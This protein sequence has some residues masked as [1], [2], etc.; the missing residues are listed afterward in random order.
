MVW[1]ASDL[2]GAKQVLP[3]CHE[4]SIWF[5]SAPRAQSSRALDEP[6]N[7]SISSLQRATIPNSPPPPPARVSG[8][9]RRADSKPDWFFWPNC[10]GEVVPLKSCLQLCSSLA[11]ALPVRVE[12]QLL[13]AIRRVRIQTVRADLARV[14]DT[15]QARAETSLCRSANLRSAPGASKAQTG[16][17]A[18]FSHTFAFDT[19][20]IRP[21][22]ELSR[23]VFAQSAR[24]CS[25]Q[26]NLHLRAERAERAIC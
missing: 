1:P 3:A 16:R 7:Q 20:P 5:A 26:L 12:G 21:E 19:S 8:H 11:L 18:Q 9:H 23:R 13:A 15:K 25:L 24:A 22:V 6:E 4:F 2:H 17:A 14:F 10:T